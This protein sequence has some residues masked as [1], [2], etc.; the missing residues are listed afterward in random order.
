MARKPPRLEHV[1][2][3]RARGKLYAYF[4]TGRK[5]AGKTVYA[6]LPDPSSPGFF[7]SYASFKA[8]RTKRS[9][10]AYTVTN[11]ANDYLKSHDFGSKAK[12]TQKV[13]HIQIGKVIDRLGKFPVD[14]LARRHIM[15][16]LQG[17]GWAPGTANA[18]LSAVGT[19]YAWGRK[20]DKTEANPTR[21]IERVKGGEHEPWPEDVLEAA[22]SCNQPRVRLA[23][24]LLYFTGQRIGDVCKM[25]WSDVRDGMVRVVQEKTRKLV[26]FD[27]AAELASELDRTAKEGL[28]ILAIDGK[29]VPQQRLRRELKAFA[30]DHGAKVV[31]HGLRKNAVN[32][33]LECGCTIAEVAAITGQTF[34]VVEHYAAKVNTRKLGKAAIYKFDQARRK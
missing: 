13:Y 26:E 32:A 28:T 34:Q 20:Y 21:D 7:D 8:A 1:K 27:L 16:V 24:H 14:Q 15:L 18:F 22:L 3:V 29:P 30:A 23:V 11:L 12:A 9:A 19:I 33:L 5:A 4:N 6:R 10:T 25:R 17:E 31:P 2:Y